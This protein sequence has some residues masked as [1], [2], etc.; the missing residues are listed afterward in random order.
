MSDLRGA[1]FCLSPVL[2]VT[3]LWYC[4]LAAIW[5]FNF[6]ATR[7]NDYLGRSTGELFII[8][9]IATAS[10]IVF[11]AASWSAVSW[12]RKIILSEKPRSL[13]PLWNGRR[14]A[15]YFGQ[16]WSTLPLWS[17]V[18]ICLVLPLANLTVGLLPVLR[19]TENVI[20]SPGRG[21][22]A[23]NSDQLYML[24]FFASIFSYFMIFF[25]YSLRYSL[26]L[27]ARA[28]DQLLRGS[29]ARRLTKGRFLR[30]FLPLGFFMFFIL[31]SF[32]VVIH[33]GLSGDTPNL[34]FT[35]L[36]LVTGIVLTLFLGFGVSTRLYLHFVP[37]A[38]LVQH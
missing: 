16:I 26:M 15:G 32:N 3:G 10:M 13:F 35:F 2:I 1:L 11:F 36:F 24:M 30:L 28:I 17:F 22:V 37:P 6:N 19:N 21:A 29:D 27:P 5:L 4:L 38:S 8:A 20:L 31:M 14:I 34:F 7:I 9:C 12:H 18:V 33:I 23:S 25:S